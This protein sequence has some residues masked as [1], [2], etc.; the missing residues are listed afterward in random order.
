MARWRLF[1]IILILLLILG[2]PVLARA[3]RGTRVVL[4]RSY[5]LPAGEHLAG[6]LAVLG[7]DVL[8]PAG[9][10]VDGDVLAVGGSALIAGRAGRH[11]FALGGDAR[12]T[13]SGATAGDILATGETRCEPG[14]AVAGQV[15][16][17]HGGLWFG[18]PWALSAN[19]FVGGAQVFLGCL[20]AVLAGLLVLVLAPGA[21]R[22]A[23]AALAHSP[24]QSMGVGLL[25][26]L[27]ALLLIPLLAISLLGLPLAALALLALA[28]GVGLGWVVAGLA[29][30]SRLLGSRRQP[31]RRPLRAGAL[32]LLL[33]AGALTL[34]WLGTPLV[35]LAGIWGLG[36][37]TLTRFG[38]RPFVA[39]PPQVAPPDPPAERPGP[40]S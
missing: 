5:A 32:G 3:R 23:G 24:L 10:S 27:A 2:Q 22:T 25:T 34:P 15:W 17:S 8:L 26:A 30:G 12:V 4:G 7:G 18:W 11:V 20:T 36:A 19:P 9:S 33:L 6:D 39:T 38:T 37:V 14:A 29:L 13:A 35:A 40:R 1:L 16:G 21:A 31:Q 28:A